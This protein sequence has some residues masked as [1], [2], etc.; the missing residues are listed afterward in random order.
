MKIS[1]NY[2]S[3]LP[4]G[5]H[6]L[7]CMV[8]VVCILCGSQ[9]IFAQ[10][11]KVSRSIKVEQLQQLSVDRYRHIYGVNANGEVLKYDSLGKE[12]GRYSPQ[13]NNEVDLIE[14]WQA[15]KIFLFY[16]ELQAFTWC[17][18]F[19]GNGVVF[20]F[21]ESMGYVTM[22]T[23]AADGNVWLFDQDEFAIKK[24]NPYTQQLVSSNALSLLIEEDE[25][26]VKFM[27]EYQNKLFVL[28]EQYC[29]QFDLFGNIEKEWMIGEE[30]RETAGWLGFYDDQLTIIKGR[31]LIQK[32]LYEDKEIVWELPKKYQQ[33][34]MLSENTW[35]G[36]WE[37]QIDWLQVP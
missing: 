1:K 34:V 19:L 32:N 13:Q 5:R 24:Y 28:S 3:F 18:R 7:G 4:N 37:A 20:E 16:E 33:V 35:I 27:R 8:L 29:Y 22:A 25:F 12:L 23:S 26:T 6:M 17:D 9:V 36:L 2:E 15:I 11:L 31:T 14:A 10:E 21:P 30:G